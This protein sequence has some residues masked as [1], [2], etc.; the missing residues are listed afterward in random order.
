MT[1]D[2]SSRFQQAITQLFALSRDAERRHTDLLA[3]CAEEYRSLSVAVARIEEQLTAAAKI[4]CPH[5]GLCVALEN[6]L[7]AQATEIT[8]L[9]TS[10]AQMQGG[11]RGI[12]T[13]AGA[14]GGA[15][16]IAA[17]IAEWVRKP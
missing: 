14:I 13:V 10:R 2:D 17:A 8:D 4:A 3:R 16:G 1:D 6:K 12:L 7:D 9:K 5:P 11:W 15:A